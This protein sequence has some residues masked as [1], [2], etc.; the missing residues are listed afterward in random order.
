MSHRSVVARAPGIFTCLLC[1]SFF[2]SAQAEIRKFTEMVEVRDGVKLA[3]DVFLPEGE[4]PFPAVLARTP[5]NKDVSAGFGEGGARAG[6]AVVI[7]DTRGRFASEGANL[8]FHTDGWGSLGDGF[9][10]VEWIKEQDWYNGKLATHGGSAGAITQFLLSGSGTEEIAFQHL[11]VGAPSLF[12]GCVYQGGVFRKALIEGW[13]AGTKFDPEAL[14]IWSDHSWDDDFWK[15]R[16][17]T[18]RWDKVNWPAVHVGGWFDIFAQPTIDGFRGFNEHGGPK[19]RGSQWL[20]MGPWTHGV[21]QP[22]AGELSFPG[23]D[24][25]PDDAADHGKYWARFLKGTNTGAGSESRVYYYVMGDVRDET[26]PGN[27]WRKSNRWP[28]FEADARAIYLNKD[29]GLSLSR[30]EANEASLGYDYDPAKPVPTVG[31]PQLTIPAG[32]RDQ[33]EV[34]TREDVLVFTS[35]ILQQPLEVTGRVG[36]KLWVSSTGVDTDFFVR[37]CD[38]YPDGTSYNL[39]EGVLRTRFREGFETEKFV[40]PGE[41][42]PL[43]I[44]LWSTS[45]IFAPGHRLRVHV[46]SSSDPGYA[47][48]PNTGERFQRSTNQKVVKNTVW[49]DE[50][51]PSHVLLPLAP[52]QDLAWQR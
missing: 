32:P 11:V 9:D 44:D 39:C 23:A 4:G 26:A 42:Y 8:P 43:E 27:E 3:T 7:Q 51:H 33:A 35:E 41:V 19:A 48:N 45:V 30:P 40:T 47:P 18:R 14:R 25:V 24:R 15:E 31:G 29:R 49:M 52:G 12:H 50:R 13:L 34:E 6:V 2:L 21:L 22:K 10:T 17:T 37:L 28:P 36:A 46:T 20:I 5:Y 1:A 16:N 38:V